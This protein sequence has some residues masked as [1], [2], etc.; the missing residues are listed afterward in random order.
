MTKK[1]K[2]PKGKNK[3]SK[4]D[5]LILPIFAHL[6]FPTTLKIYPTFFIDNNFL[7][8]IIF[9]NHDNIYITI[10]LTKQTQLGNLE[11]WKI[12]LLHNP[13]TKQS[14]LDTMIFFS[15]HDYCLD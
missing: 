7:L 10:Y 5:N 6:L 12:H 15:L 13:L 11:K 14:Q 1:N 9:V 3:N 4:L 8:I 2:N